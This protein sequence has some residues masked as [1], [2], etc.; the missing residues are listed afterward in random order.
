MSFECSK[1][2]A[3]KAYL[4]Q[5]V[6]HEGADAH[7][8]PLRVDKEEGDVGLVELDVRHHEAKADHHLAVLDHHAEVR[9][10]EA[11]GHCPEERNPEGGQPPKRITSVSIPILSQDLAGLGASTI[12]WQG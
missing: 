2:A 1:K 6:D 8:A 10:L 11:L 12:N 5:V 4:N 9:I 7:S 3:G